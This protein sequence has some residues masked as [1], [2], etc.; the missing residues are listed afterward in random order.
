MMNTKPLLFALLALFLVFAAVQMT[1]GIRVPSSANLINP[2]ATPTGSCPCCK[3][4]V[5]V[6]LLCTEICCK[7]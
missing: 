1:E 3:W 6:F 5:K 4:E 2:Q 7:N